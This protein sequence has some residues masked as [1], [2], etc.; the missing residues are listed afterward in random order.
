MKQLIETICIVSLIGCIACTGKKTNTVQLHQNV[1]SKTNT[2]VDSVKSYTIEQYVN[3][4]YGY[5][6]Y[7]PSY[8][9]PQG[10]ADNSDGQIFRSSNGI[11]LSVWGTKNTLSFSNT[12]EEE[13]AFRKQCYKED[14]SKITYEKRI[15]DTYTLS[16]INPDGKIFYQKIVFNKSKDIFYMVVLEYPENYRQEGDEIIKTSINSF[17]TYIPK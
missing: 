7:Y 15:K 13:F 14:K 10:E 17:P 2:S 5:I 9:I 1:E 4:W 16:G 12:P 11:K 8:L 6:L 3:S